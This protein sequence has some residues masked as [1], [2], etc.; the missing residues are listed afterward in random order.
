MYKND[1][2]EIDLQGEFANDVKIKKVKYLKDAIQNL[3][4][5]VK[6][7]SVTVYVVSKNKA[8]EVYTKFIENETSKK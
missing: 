8:L 1:V 4:L 6:N 3:K 2:F 7:N 5:V